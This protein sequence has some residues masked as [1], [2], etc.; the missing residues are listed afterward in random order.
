MPQDQAANNQFSTEPDPSSNTSNGT[1][2]APYPTSFEHIVNLITTGQPIP[3]IKDIPDT[4]LSGQ[5]S[6]PTANKRRKPWEKD[7]TDDVALPSILGQSSKNESDKDL[8]Y[9]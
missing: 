5:A 2:P 1:Q 3:G 8:P 4:V 6:Q 9:T 7:P